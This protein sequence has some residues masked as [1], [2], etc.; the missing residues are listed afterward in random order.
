M[1]FVFGSRRAD[2][3]IAGPTND[4]IASFRG[5]DFIWPGGGSDFVL[6]GR[7][8]DTVVHRVSEN[9]G[10]R[11]VYFGG[12]GNDTL[13]IELTAD[14]WADEAIKADLRAFATRLAEGGARVVELA[15]LGIVARSFEMLK[16]VVDGV[17]IDP[18]APDEDVVID[19]SGSTADETVEALDGRDYAVTTG[20]GNDEIVLGAGDDTVSSGEGDDT[21]TIGAGDD[22]VYTGP[23]N[24]TIIAGNGAGNDVID[25][26]AGLDTVT[27]PSIVNSGILVDLR[28]I[29]RSAQV[30]DGIALADLLTGAT[31]A[32]TGQAYAASLP[33]GYAT[34]EEIGVDILIDVERVEGGAGNDTLIGSDGDNRILGNAGDDELIGNG[35][36][37]RLEGGDGR[38]TLE[39]GDGDDFLRP[40]G[41]DDLVSG[42]LGQ[43]TLILQGA[44]S[45]YVIENVSG[46]T[47]RITD[48]VADRDGTD[49]FSSISRIVFTDVTLFDFQLPPAGPITGTTDAD[50]LEGT[51]GNDRIFG[52]DGND[53]VF[54]YDGNDYIVGDE[55][56]DEVDGGEGFDTLDY[57]NPG[58][59][60][61]VADLRVGTVVDQFGGTD[62][63]TNV[64]FFFGTTGDDTFFTSTNGERINPGAGNDTIIGNTGFD[65]LSYE[66]Q[67]G[68]VRGIEVLF[69][70]TVVGEG[71]VVVD[72]AGDRDTFFSIEGLAG[73]QLSDILL[74]GAGAQQFVDGNPDGLPASGAPD[75]IDGGDGIDSL[76]ITGPGG[77]SIDMEALLTEA[78][79]TAFI[80]SVFGGFG[81]LAPET[82]ARLQAD[83]T[84]FFSFTN[85]A[86]ET[87][88]GRSIESILL[89]R[90]GDDYVAGD[91]ADNT[92]SS[93]AGADTLLGR[94]GNDT[95]AGGLDDDT[96]DGG[97][98]ADVLRGEDGSD[99][100]I[101]GADDD[102]LSGG[103]GSDTFV[104]LAGDGNDR[105]DDFE[106]G[107]DR[108]DLSGQT[109]Q[110]LTEGDFNGDG[111]TDTRV[112]FSSGDLVDIL[113]VTGV[114][115]PDLLL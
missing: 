42:G 17:E 63:V 51:P 45:D 87:S 6:A 104:F 54:G 2:T 109:I 74:G 37:D 114:S 10:Q 46:G 50:L 71:A 61:I 73:S 72:T 69:S 39:G 7:G 80:D 76:D 98:G 4:F 58:S 79:V 16:V 49:T 95:L 60:P 62:T 59:Q 35:G 33:V 96:L 111:E 24:D 92:F 43:D 21:V 38:D 81:T 34:G 8:A 32:E 53:T 84:G 90:G 47:Y 25:G 44:S 41:G 105:I 13:V 97:E 70:E 9:S 55:G 77:V 5:A 20:A 26:G 86:G 36:A 83:L 100:L 29:D 93:F 89:L 107:L 106:L 85:G 66:P 65:L 23:G 67:P 101:G 112:T 82:A 99:R 19:L 12:R 18:L 94:G 11:D 48:Q 113:S 1:P 27:F 15:S 56:D 22:V 14:E 78:E 102:V 88:I 64:E 40:G 3:I 68:L 115:E 31:D 110:S 57:S 28:Q 52:L 75:L 103:L 91:D 108:F 30:V